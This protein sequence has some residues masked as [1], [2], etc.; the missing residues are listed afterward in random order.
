MKK[1]RSKSCYFFPFGFTVDVGENEAEAPKGGFGQ[2]GGAEVFYL[3]KEY[4]NILPYVF[5]FLFSME[6]NSAAFRIE[7][8]K[9]GED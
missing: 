9:G 6:K 1:K 7:L 4:K 8:R 2:D 5:L 3:N